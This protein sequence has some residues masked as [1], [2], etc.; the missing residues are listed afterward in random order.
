MRY[1][2][3]VHIDNNDASVLHIAM[4]NLTNYLKAVENKDWHVVVVVNGPGV[5]QF[6]TGNLTH[7]SQITAL[8]ARGV[9]FLLC[10]NAL[11]AFGVEHDTLLEGCSIVGA[12]IVEIVERQNNGFAYVKP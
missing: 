4:S 8:A 3:L 7:G 1:D 5:Q 10:Q 11:T 6:T 2:L 9:Q 12:G